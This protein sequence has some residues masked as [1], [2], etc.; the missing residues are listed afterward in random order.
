MGMVRALRRGLLLPL[1][2]ASVPAAAEVVFT[3]TVTPSDPA[4]VTGET[5]VVV[6]PQNTGEITLDPRGAIVVDGGAQWEA[7]Q[8]LVGANELALA[9]MTVSG[10]GTKVSVVRSGSLSSPTLGV[11]QRGSGHL[12]VDGG[13]WLAIGSNQQGGGVMTLGPYSSQPT[14]GPATVEVAGEG[15]LLTIGGQLVLNGAATSKLRVTDGAVV[16]VGAPSTS[17]EATVAVVGE[18]SIAGERSE[19]Q[20]GGLLIGSLSSAPSTGLGGVVRVGAGA[21]VRPYGQSYVGSASIS[22]VGVLQ[23]E[24]GTFSLPLRQVDGVVRGSGVLT[25]DVTIANGGS[26]E[27][28]A[29]EA[30]RV[31][32]ML[33]SRGEI[34]AEGGRLDVYGDFTND[35]FGE[36]PGVVEISNGSAGF[37]G[38]STNESVMRLIGG[39]FDFKNLRTSEPFFQSGSLHAV[40]SKIAVTGSMSNRGVLELISSDLLITGT[41]RNETGS[42][43]PGRVVLD[44]SQ[45]LTPTTSFNPQFSNAGRIEARA[46]HN[47]VQPRVANQGASSLVVGKD[48]SIEFRVGAEFLDGVTLQADAQVVVGGGPLR[49]DGGT[50]IELT[51]GNRVHPAIVSSSFVDLFG[52]LALTMSDL[53]GL[54]VGQSYSLVTA[55]RVYSAFSQVTLPDLPGTLEFVPQ[56][57]ETE[58]SLLVVDSAVTLPGDYNGDGFVDAADYTVLRDSELQAI[59][60]LALVTWQTNYGR[61]LPGSGM[62]IPEPASAIAMGGGLLAFVGSRL[63]RAAEIVEVGGEELIHTRGHQRA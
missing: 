4:G 5:T 24:G 57:T 54:A 43:D 17:N 11:A 49:V 25:R 13:A 7:A 28:G 22:P 2:L 55:E 35:D 58:L 26:L 6:G 15:T 14:V 27:V 1:L 32:G 21:I 38:R 51:A 50:S 53:S 63:R 20:T 3:G 39:E 34:T 56:L 42:R 46:G 37:F 45:I 36:N 8:V 19:L 12:R 60:P 47:V 62:P 41:L 40:Q 10:M 16:R 9:R 18:L 29:A 30:L 23:M 33:I 61:W 52:G 48:A 59:N 44:H 31:D